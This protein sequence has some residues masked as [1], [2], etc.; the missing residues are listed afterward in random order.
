MS[1]A[2]LVQTGGPGTLEGSELEQ[3]FI[4]F[5]DSMITEVLRGSCRSETARV[6]APVPALSQCP[7]ISVSLIALILVV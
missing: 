4:M 6:W 2:S 5:H 7:S 3:Q 1:D